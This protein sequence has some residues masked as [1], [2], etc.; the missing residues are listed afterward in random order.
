MKITVET[1][2]LVKAVEKIALANGKEIVCAVGKDKK[3]RTFLTMRSSNKAVQVECNLFAEGVDISETKKFSLPTDFIA[4]VKTLAVGNEH[5]CLEMEEDDN[6]LYLKTESAVVPLAVASAENA[7]CIKSNNPQKQNCFGLV[8]E[9]EVLQGDVARVL[10]TCD[11][12]D[13][14]VMGDT[15]FVMPFKEMDNDEA[16]L[17]L[18][19]LL[20]RSI[21][22]A[23]GSRMA[24]ELA[25]GDKFFN[26]MVAAKKLLSVPASFLMKISRHFQA[27]T[28]KWFVFE[29][30]IVITDGL[31]FYTMTMKKPLSNLGSSDEYLFEEQDVEFKVLLDKA[32]LTRAFG[33]TA[34]NQK[35]QMADYLIMEICDGKVKFLSIDEKNMVCANVDSNN[36]IGQIRIAFNRSWVLKA[37]SACTGDHIQIA[38]TTEKFPIF[39]SDSYAMTRTMILPYCI[40]DEETDGNSKKESSEDKTNS[41]KSSDEG[42]SKKETKTS[43]DQTESEATSDK[44]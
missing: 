36:V 21:M 26:N 33:I 2:E 31:D 34:L 39:V 25:A 44:K 10:P 14:S 15:I 17:R 37:V 13:N 24:V 30:Q 38:G 27:D 7:V 22:A 6:L 20:R 9:T 16:E 19:T 28:T 35:G 3:E 5:I 29:N 40:E 23:S 8:V 41:K 43:E 4:C 11:T 12:S 32:E 42:N 1:K 18:V